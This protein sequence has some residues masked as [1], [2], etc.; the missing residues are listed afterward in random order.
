M[1]SSPADCHS[2]LLPLLHL[3]L[4]AVFAVFALRF[5]PLSA[6]LLASLP[7]F[8]FFFFFLFLPFAP[9][10]S[11]LLLSLSPPSPIASRTS[12]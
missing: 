12:P 1:V 8:L 2:F 11:F 6:F 5:P 10:L 9:F 3:L 4:P 7:S